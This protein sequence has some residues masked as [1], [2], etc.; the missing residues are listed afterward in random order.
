MR[1]VLLALALVACGGS[2]APPA[3]PEDCPVTLDGGS[4]EAALDAA[5]DA[6][7]ASVPDAAPCKLRADTLTPNR[8]PREGHVLLVVT[9]CGFLRTKEVRIYVYPTLFAIVDDTHLAVYGTVGDWF[10]GPN[11][12]PWPIVIKSE[13]ETAEVTL[14]YEPGN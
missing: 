11:P 13:T 8:I 7:D 5:P 1:R 6:L 14:T 3:P 10:D 2:T 9:G 12:Q 4:P